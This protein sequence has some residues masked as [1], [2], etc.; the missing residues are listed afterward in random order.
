[1]LQRRAGVVTAC[2]VR[3]LRARNE[4]MDKCRMADRPSSPRFKTDMPQIPG[5]SAQT[6]RTHPGFKPVR[7]IGF[8]AVLLFLLLL[9]RW[10]MSP[11]APHGAP[12]TPAPQIDIPAPA[13]DANAALPHATE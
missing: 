3:L 2:R 13:P 4:L 11:K 5:I 9:V 8:V 7:L 1:M 10:M 6:T 12:V